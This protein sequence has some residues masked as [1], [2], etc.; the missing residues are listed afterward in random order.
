M[1]K[2]ALIAV[3]SIMLFGNMTSARA[4]TKN[5]LKTKMTS[6]YT[7]NGSTFKLADD[8]SVLVERY[9][10]QNNLSEAELNYIS[11]K[12]DEVLAILRTSNATSIETLSWPTKEK[13]LALVTDVSNNTR[14]QATVLSGAR[15][16]IKNLDGTDFAIVGKN[17][18]VKQT[19]DTSIIACASALSL[20][21]IGLAIRKFRK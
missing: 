9:L 4:I 5:E 15:I 12:V 18:I 16:S 19:N 2:F 17:D 21:G 6:S 10:Q 8:K 14:V 20:L 13:L 7:I 1:K 11:T 3:L